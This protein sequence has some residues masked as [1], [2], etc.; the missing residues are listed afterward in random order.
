VEAAIDVRSLSTGVT[1]R[2]EHILSDE[3]LDAARYPHMTFKSTKVAPRGGNRAR[4]HGDLTIHG[5]TRPVVLDAEHFGPVRSPFGGEITIGITAST[6]ID[7]EDFGI[8]W[9][10]DPL[11]SGGF[12]AGKD[13]EI[14][15]D[16][17]ADLPNE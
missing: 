7:R 8:L 9:G 16:V 3:M 5:V 17:E 10:N 14:T 11:E 6:K 12:L 1:K 2:D 4:V 15:I 13:V